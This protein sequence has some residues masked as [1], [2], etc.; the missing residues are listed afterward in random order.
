[1]VNYTYGLT[2]GST[3]YGRLRG[4]LS[5]P[6]VRAIHSRD[7]RRFLPWKDTG[8]PRGEPYRGRIYMRDHS[9]GNHY[10]LAPS[11]AQGLTLAYTR[12]LDL[13]S[14]ALPRLTAESAGG[15]ST[16]FAEGNWTEK[17]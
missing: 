11:P 1:M 12:V 10:T 14:G 2:K 13:A 9:K 16:G 8:P 4:R 7:G 17:Q 6:G 15:T 3:T 5:Q